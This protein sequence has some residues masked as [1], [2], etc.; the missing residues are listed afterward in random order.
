M[1]RLFSVLLLLHLLVITGCGYKGPLVLPEADTP[2]SA[3]AENEKK[4]KTQ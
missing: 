4:K 2:Q 3:D 1:T